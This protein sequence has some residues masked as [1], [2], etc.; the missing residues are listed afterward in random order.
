MANVTMDPQRTGSKLSG[1]MAKN[2]ARAER[3]RALKKEHP[4]LTW[5]Q[6]GAACGVTARAAQGWSL[7]GRL[8][9]KNAVA[10]AELCGV[11]VDF[12]WSGETTATAVA[13]PRNAAVSARLT[14]IERRLEDLP[15]QVAAALVDLLQE[16]LRREL[17]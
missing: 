2:T 3:I 6:I 16:E 8:A 14:A 17:D 11:T 7:T 4:E 5:E 15:D 1:S 13:A 9:Y 10:L 12:I